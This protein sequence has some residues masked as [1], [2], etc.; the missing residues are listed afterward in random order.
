M[1]IS[2]TR[3][4]TIG[5]KPRPQDSELGFGNYTSD[6]MFML[7]YTAARGW[8]APDKSKWPQQQNRS[9]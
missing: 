3:S 2:L 6:H 9:T 7:D 8:H 4:T 1:E 5:R